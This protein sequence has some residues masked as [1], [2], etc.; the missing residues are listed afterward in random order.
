MTNL[1]IGIL[2]T[3]MGGIFLT[4]AYTNWND[5][6]HIVRNGIK[7]TGTVSEVRYNTGKS[8]PKRSTAKAPVVQFYTPEGRLITY[9]STTYTTPCPYEVG[10]IVDI[11]YLPENPQ[12][13]TLN[14]MDAWVL[15]LVFGIFGSLALLAGLG[16]LLSRKKGVETG[17]GR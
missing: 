16:L 13:A 8:S 17:V 1:I 15:P 3:C 10:Q 4:I 11:W 5:T 14:G 6:T 9:Y 2:L 12:T 7:T